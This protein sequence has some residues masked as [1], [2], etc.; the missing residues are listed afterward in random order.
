MTATLGIT[1][2]DVAISPDGSL[3]YAAGAWTPP[4]YAVPIDDGNLR[5]YDAETGALLNTISVGTRLG[6]V[7]ISPDGTFM[8][9]TELA[10]AANTV[11]V[12]KIDL[13]TNAVQTF[14]TPTDSS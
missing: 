7:D 3:I 8:M 2:E 12:Y 10:P 5:I 9:V 1:P 11:T 14:S 6:A 13:A 4:N